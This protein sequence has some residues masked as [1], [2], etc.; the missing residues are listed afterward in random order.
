[1]RSQIFELWLTF[2]PGACAVIESLWSELW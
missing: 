1:M 2:G